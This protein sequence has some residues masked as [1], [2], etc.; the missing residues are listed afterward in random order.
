MG[1]LAGL[2]VGLGLIALLESRDNGLRSEDDVLRVLDLPVLASI[3]LI[4]TAD[5]RRRERRR[6]VFG[7]V[8]AAVALVVAAGAAAFAWSQGLIH[9]PV[10]VR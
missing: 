5:D 3:P 7:F 6:R 2:G 9:L 8:G 1:A 10:S 4:E